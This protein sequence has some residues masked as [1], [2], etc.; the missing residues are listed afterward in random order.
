[1]PP[2]S[3][4]SD[5]AS[6]SRPTFT[7]FDWDDTLC[8]TSFLLSHP[9]FIDP[10]VGSEWPPELC[11]GLRRHTQAVI[12]VLKASAELGKICIVTLA[13][14]A[15]V[16]RSIQCIMPGIDQVIKSLGVEVR[17]A[18]TSKGPIEGAETDSNGS[19]AKFNE[20]CIDALQDLK[21]TAM[22]RCLE[23]AYGIGN[24]QVAEVDIC[25]IGDSEIEGLAARDVAQRRRANGPCLCKVLKLR[26][27]P[28]LESLTAQLRAVKHWLPQVAEHDG[29]A[30]LDIDRSLTWA[31]REGREGSPS[32]VVSPNAARRLGLYHQSSEATR[33]GHSDH[34]RALEVPSY[35]RGRSRQNHSAAGLRYAGRESGGGL[36]KLAWCPGSPRRSPTQ[37]RAP[38]CSHDPHSHRQPS[39]GVGHRDPHTP[40]TRAG[41]GAGGGGTTYLPALASVRTGRPAG[42]VGQRGA[43][44]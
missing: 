5:A 6:R 33:Y 9:V 26:D 15:W 2:V 18:R 39:A 14:E 41:F 23:A 20:A 7:V 24:G 10:A 36:P 12:D 35:P 27:E 42:C 21:A 34:S 4:G 30:L 44:A 25:S 38:R 43:Y 22:I 3:R 13:E 31:Q 16:W 1:M 11:E 37:V 8:P 29:D 40:R 19:C 17:S 28:S 32:A